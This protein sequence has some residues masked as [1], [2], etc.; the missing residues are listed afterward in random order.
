MY[1]NKKNKLIYKKGVIKFE[2]RI[3]NNIQYR[4]G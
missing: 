1:K 4:T 3:H 2:E